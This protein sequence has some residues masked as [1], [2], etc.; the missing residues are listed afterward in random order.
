MIFIRYP[1]VWIFSTG[2]ELK[3]N[4]DDGYIRDTNSLMIKQ[5]LAQDKYM[6]SVYNRGIF[7]DKYVIFI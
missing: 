3:S 7:R 1:T 5:L 4:E 2:D 6:G